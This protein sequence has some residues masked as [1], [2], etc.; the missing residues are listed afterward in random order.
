MILYHGSLEIVRAPEIRDSNRT[1]DYGKGFYLTSSCPQAEKWVRSKLK[2]KLTH[3]YVNIYEY[4]P[5]LESELKILDFP[6]AS[7]EWVD[8]V[9]ANRTDRNFVHDF[10]I[11]KGPVADDN[12]YAAF[13]V[14]ESGLLSKEQLIVELK[15]YKLVNQILLH[16]DKA[17]PI[18]KFVEAKEVT[19]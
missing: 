5:V 10:D 19:I 2:N 9:M 8:F 4:N 12:V 6:L 7:E 14:Y 15:T 11:V 17:I 13:A 18:I 1:L 3:G 16:T